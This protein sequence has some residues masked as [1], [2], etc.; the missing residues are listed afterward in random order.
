MDEFGFPTANFADLDTTVFTN[1][2]SIPDNEWV[3]IAI[4][5]EYD[6]TGTRIILTKN[7]SQ[8]GTAWAASAFTEDNTTWTK[9]YIGKELDTNSNAH[10]DTKFYSGFLWEIGFSNQ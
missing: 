7:G 9:N 2:T 10:V 6:G 3:F 1:D 5:W 4:Y 8:T